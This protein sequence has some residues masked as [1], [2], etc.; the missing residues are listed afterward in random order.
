MLNMLTASLE[1]DDDDDDDDDDE[2]NLLLF[3]ELNSSLPAQA[4]T[5]LRDST[6]TN[7]TRSMKMPSYQNSF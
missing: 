4:V 5:L 6:S 1:D 7:T 2:Q 3:G